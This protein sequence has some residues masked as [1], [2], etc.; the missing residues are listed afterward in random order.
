MF[1]FGLPL[2]FQELGSNA[3]G[4]RLASVCRHSVRFKVRRTLQGVLA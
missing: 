1:G 2:D 3:S 4:F